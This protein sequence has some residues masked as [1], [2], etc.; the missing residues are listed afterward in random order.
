MPLMSFEDD[1]A[2]YVARIAQVR[3]REFLEVEP[4][5]IFARCVAPALADNPT[6]EQSCWRGRL[7][8]GATTMAA[9]ATHGRTKRHPSAQRKP[10]REG[11]AKL[12]RRLAEV[13]A[14]RKLVQKAE[15]SRAC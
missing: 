3:S 15:A 10:S 5:L 4:R 2:S 6:R 12:A 1:E 9:R 8:E 14:L 7:Q 13:Q 11:A